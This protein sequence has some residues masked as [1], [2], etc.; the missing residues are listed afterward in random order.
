[1][2]YVHESLDRRH[3]E[4]LIALRNTGQLGRAADTLALSPSAASHRL[5]EAE[6][7][8]GISL[9]TIDGR[10]VQ[11][12]PAA[13]HLAEVGDMTRAAM[14]SAEETA[15]WMT[16]AARPAVRIALDF[17]D[18]APW[19]EKLIGLDD[20]PCDLDFVRVGFNAAH[21]AVIERRADL[22]VV[23]LAAATEP[24]NTLVDD[25]LV[26]LVRNDHPAAE[27]GVLDPLD[28][29]DAVYLTAGDRPTHGFEHHEFFE[30]A[31]VNPY[32][33]R[34]VESLAMIMR[35]MRSFGGVTVQPSLAID[36]VQLEGLTVVP[37]RDAHI[38][39]RW[40]TVHRPNATSD[41]L[42]IID[43]IRQISTRPP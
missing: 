24:S 4:L 35:L 3:I 6:K 38:A 40:E 32:R 37:L 17:Y 19:F 31:G 15:R 10:S 21:D 43:A 25:H 13:I 5:K 29:S 1:M 18:T 2:Q 33:L 12:T 26:G 20:L 39:V 41:E 22:G 34:K 14:R 28:I 23:V 27:R 42:A 8:L 16:S 11:L 9:T 30:P 7:R 36:T